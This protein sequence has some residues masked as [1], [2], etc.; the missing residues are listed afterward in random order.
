[1]VQ[2]KPIFI[3]QYEAPYI[4]NDRLFRIQNIY[5]SGQLFGSWSS[6]TIN[7][8]SF[9]MSAVSQKKV[10]F[11]WLFSNNI[12]NSDKQSSETEKTIIKQK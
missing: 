7:S 9:G 12:N 11:D 5:P 3:V 4:P 10:T 8:M 6:E 1:M 2:T